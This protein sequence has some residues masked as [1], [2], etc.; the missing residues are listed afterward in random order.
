[1]QSLT[2]S[3]FAAQ[4]CM[5]QNM[6]KPSISL[7]VPNRLHS[8]DSLEIMSDIRKTDFHGIPKSLVKVEQKR[9]CELRGLNYK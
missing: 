1:M 2:R 8:R 4:I 7:H 5:Q 3:V 6:N 9:T